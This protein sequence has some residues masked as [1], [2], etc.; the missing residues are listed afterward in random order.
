[1]KRTQNI[2]LT[3][4]RKAPKMFAFKPLAFAVT[5]TTLV[6][7][8]DDTQESQVY[9]TVDDCVS[10][11]PDQAQQCELAYKQA[12]AEAIKSG[13]KYS[14]LAACI[15]DF[16]EQNCNSYT[17]QNNQSFFMPF[18]TGYLISSLIGGNNYR[19]APLYTSYSR[20]SP[21]YGKW[22]S[23]DGNLL[24]S[25]N[26]NK[27]KVSSNDFKPKPTV[28]RTMSRGGFGSTI[29]AKSRFGGKSSRSSW[30]G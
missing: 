23:T 6:G 3:A 28:R 30:G 12:E 20:R 5:A 1:M 7:C 21:A 14:S 27:V 18:M 24:G 13:P 26:S 2:D 11:N 10:G 29:A 16:G 25:A 15:E 4:M 8:S 9:R 22:T 19:S 17:S